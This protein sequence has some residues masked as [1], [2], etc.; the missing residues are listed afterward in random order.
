MSISGCHRNIFYIFI[1]LFLVQNSVLCWD[2]DNL[3]L[4]D[5]VEEVNENFYDV[6][7][8]TR[9]ASSSEIKKAYRKKTLVLHP[10][11][12]EA[13]DAE[14]QFRKLVAVYEVLKDEEKREKYNHVLDFGLPDWRQPVYYYRKARKLGLVELALV[15]CLIITIGQYF[16]LWAVYLERR[17]ALEDFFQSKKKKET[18]KKKCKA[19]ALNDQID[20]DLQETLRSIPKPNIRNLWPITFTVWSIKTAIAVPTMVKEWKEKKRLMK[21]WAKLEKEER[22]RQEALYREELELRKQKRKNKPEPR[23]AEA[24]EAD[25]APVVYDAPKELEQETADAY[26][27]TLKDGAWTDEDYVMLSKAYIKFPGG[28]AKRWEKIAEMVGRPVGEV[29]NKCKQMKGNFQMNLSS[30]VQ[31]GT[32]N[33]KKQIDISDEIISTLSPESIGPKNDN[34]EVTVRKRNKNKPQSDT[35]KISVTKNSTS[36]ETGAK[37]SSQKSGKQNRTADSQPKILNGAANDKLVLKVKDDKSKEAKKIEETSEGKALD[38]E[39]WSQNQ[40]VIL[41]WALKQYPKTTEQRWEKIAEH[42]PGKNKDDCVARF[43]YLADLVKQKKQQQ[44]Q[45]S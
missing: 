21:E 4:Y 26:K 15:L 5:L 18:K 22:E 12:N 31:A 32:K 34:S 16:V 6:L 24:V 39:S 11:K 19:A 41:E 43:K 37:V 40:Q 44:Q 7:G 8:V 3:E 33:S 28:T 9:S 20:E 1:F 35:E 29:T 27:Q 17:L 23:I 25:L 14:E 38:A 36:V 30:S 2:T 45:Q 42:I 13:V 10:D